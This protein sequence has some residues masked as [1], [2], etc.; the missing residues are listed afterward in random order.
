MWL[1][2]VHIRQHQPPFPVPAWILDPPQSWF[3]AS[4]TEQTIWRQQ[5]VAVDWPVDQRHWMNQTVLPGVANL[6]TLASF[7]TF[8]WTL[9]VFKVTS[10]KSSYFFMHL[11]TRL[12]EAAYEGTNHSAISPQRAA[13]DVVSPAPSQS[14]N[15]QSRPQSGGHTRKEDT[16][17]PEKSRLETRS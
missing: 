11:E 10:D 1:Y 7:Q 14:F 2:S 5:T 6:L 4:P 16:P 17:T 3:Q 8:L 9:Y 12:L 15:K 13:S